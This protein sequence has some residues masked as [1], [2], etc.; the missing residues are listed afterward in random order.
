MESDRTG[1]DRG[2]NVVNLGFNGAKCD[3][4]LHCTNSQSAF[5]SVIIMPIYAYMPIIIISFIL[6]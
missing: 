1:F 5:F 3:V 6:E 2:L 4:F